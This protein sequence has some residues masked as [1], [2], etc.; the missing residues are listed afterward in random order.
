MS[1]G[2]AKLPVLAE[3]SG[4]VAG[5]DRAWSLRRQDL[6]SM[7]AVR[8]KLAGRRAVL[9]TGGDEPIRVLAVAVAS[10]AAA[11]GL[12]TALLECDLARPRL[13]AELG[14][15][16]SPGLHEYLRW[17]ATPEEIL[18]PVVL[19]GP[20]SA[21]AQEPLVCISAGR[22]ASDPA[23]LLGL[24]SFRHMTAKLRGAY[25]LLV[26]VGPS[27]VAGNGSLPALAA[28]ADAVLAALGRE[29]A[30]GRENRELRSAIG[31]LPVSPLGAVVVGG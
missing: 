12:R 16:Q 15:A 23:T 22:G 4:P 7:A 17:E 11:A 21:A 18:Q 9:V 19:A 3:I 30:S 5:A 1:G 25:E 28:E 6:E 24:Q 13:A 14:L 27:L 26:I 20:A 31:R 29:Q 8:D 2:R 10:I